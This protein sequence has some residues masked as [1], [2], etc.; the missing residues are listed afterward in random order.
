MKK[1]SE[2]KKEELKKKLLDLVKWK[3]ESWPVTSKTLQEMEEFCGEEIDPEVP[4][5]CESSLYILLGKEDARTLLAKLRR[6]GELAG[7]YN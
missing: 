2:T 4:F 7:I 5:F 6:I 3:P 1:G